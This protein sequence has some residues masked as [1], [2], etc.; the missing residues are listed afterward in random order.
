MA[1]ITPIA[2]PGT[3][4]RLLVELREGESDAFDRLVPLV[5]AALKDVSHA[6]LRRSPGV[7]I[8]TTELVHETYLKMAPGE[9][10]DWE[11]RGHFLGVAARAMR[12]ILVDE[13][14]RRLAG[15]RGDGA[16]PVTL[17]DAK[18]TVPLEPVELIALDQALDR[19]DRLNPRLRQV[20]ELRYFAGLTEREIAELLDVTTRTVE[21]DWVK[22]RLFLRRELSPEG[23]DGTSR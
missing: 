6:Q 23:A 21:R 12:Q 10:V 20:V 22:A 18:G 5:Y 19:L 8:S 1:R 15:K 2:D 11:G 17:T 16:R 9:G 3:V 13:A 4:T 7:D 14:R